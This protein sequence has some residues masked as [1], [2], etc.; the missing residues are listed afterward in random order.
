MALLPG[1]LCPGEM[2]ADRILSMGL[3][4]L[5]DNQNRVQTNDLCEIEFLEIELLDHLTVCKEITD[6]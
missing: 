2:E 3:I 5:F 4:D 1:L 6:Y